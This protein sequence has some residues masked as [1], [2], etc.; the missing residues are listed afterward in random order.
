MGF[1]SFAR[2]FSGAAMAGVVALLEWASDVRRDFPMLLRAAGFVNGSPAFDEVTTFVSLVIARKTFGWSSAVNPD[3]VK[4]ARR[5]VEDAASGGNWRR[6]IAHA[7]RIVVR[8]SVPA[9]Q[10]DAGSE[11]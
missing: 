2:R 5:C 10:P 6:H 9:G 4:W 3:V 11:G 7:S 1:D 8:Q